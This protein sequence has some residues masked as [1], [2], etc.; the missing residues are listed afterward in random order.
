[1]EFNIALGSQTLKSEAGQY[2]KLT[3]QNFQMFKNWQDVNKNN[4]KFHLVIPSGPQPVNYNPA[5]TEVI[6]DEKTYDTQCCDINNARWAFANDLVAQIVRAMEAWSP[7]PPNFRYSVINPPNPVNPP[8]PP[9][10]YPGSSHIMHLRVE[11]SGSWDGVLVNAINLQCWESDGESY[12]L[13]GANRLVSANVPPTERSMR[14][15]Y[16]PLPGVNQAQW[17]FFFLYPMQLQTQPYIYMHS[18]LSNFS[19]ETSSLS[20]PYE[21]TRPTTDVATSTIVAKIPVGKTECVYDANYES[22]YFLNIY[23]RHINS[24][25]LSLRDERNRPIGR[26]FN[27]ASLSASVDDRAADPPNGATGGSAQSTLGNLQFNCVFK[28]DIVQAMLPNE[29]MF[30]PIPNP[31]NPKTSGLLLDPSNPPNDNDTNPALRALTLAE[32]ARLSGSVVRTGGALGR[33]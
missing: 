22:V 28:V 4:N 1:D 25:Y 7:N 14:I 10:V 19:I 11:Q 21:A 17:D 6:L 33:L 29:R 23:D 12:N 13:F 5:N 26:L 27:S 32:N 18:R 8:N 31:L 9:G 15:Q 20:Q 2:I 16:L 3:L 24:V 30:A